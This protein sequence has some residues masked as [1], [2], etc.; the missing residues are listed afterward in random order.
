VD[1]R[2]H[3]GKVAIK[4]P[5]VVTPL[6]VG[7]VGVL[8][9]LLFAIARLFIAADGDISQFVVAG[10]MF[11]DAEEVDPE[12]HVFDSVGYDGQF[13]W[14]LAAD[15][16]ERGMETHR[17]VELDQEVRTTRIVYPT[18]AYVGALG[19]PGLVV[20]SL[21]GVNVL[22]FGALSAAAAAFARNRGQLPMTGLLVA[23]S[24][25]LVMSM[26]RD[27]SEV[28]MVAAIVAGVLAIGR[29]RYGWATAAFVLAVATHEQAAY[30]VLVYG[31]VRILVMIRGRLRGNGKP[32]DEGVTL[33]PS[34]GLPDLP[35]V[36]AGIAFV[37][38]QLWMAAVLGEIPLPA[39]VTTMPPCPSWDCCRRWAT[40]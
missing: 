14:R 2:P 16:V 7:A 37:S 19:Q 35:W 15:P 38:V 11:G 17:G 18:L 9:A 3:P 5:N 1:T 13:F 39:P 8:M 32:V 29:E 20:W 36:G 22:M 31:V 6:Q 10:S 21:V 23:A 33:A 4:S 28:T 25:G 24:S 12:I 27:L 34:P 40:G 30:V 26:A